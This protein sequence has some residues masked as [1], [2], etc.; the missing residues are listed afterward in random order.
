MYTVWKI[1][2]SFTGLNKNVFT[3]QLLWKYLISSVTSILLF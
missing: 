2:S 1:T 3:T